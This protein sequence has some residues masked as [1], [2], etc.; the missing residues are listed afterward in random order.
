MQT[1][2]KVTSR[3]YDSGK[4][5][6]DISTIEVDEKPENG[7]NEYRTHDEYTDYFE[8]KKEAQEFVKGVYGA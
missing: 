6:A 1:Y 4:T 3:F 5:S 7:Y 2:Y 8:T